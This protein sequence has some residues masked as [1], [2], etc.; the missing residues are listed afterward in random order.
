METS[1]VLSLLANLFVLLAWWARGEQIKDL[2]KALEG[3]RRAADAWQTRAHRAE[4]RL[5][6]MK[7]RFL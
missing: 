5:E 2:A 4:Q 1:L 6:Q 3:K 7:K